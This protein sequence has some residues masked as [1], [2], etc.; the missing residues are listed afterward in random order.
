MRTRPA[1]LL[2]IAGV[3]F[4]LIALADMPYGY[5]TFLRLAVPGIAVAIAVIA[6]K[7]G[8]PGWLW[9]L[10]PIAIIWNPLLPIS[11]D[12]AAWVSLDVLAAVTFGICAAQVKTDLPTPVPR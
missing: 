11:M 1:L 4:S 8:A 9:A 12:R 10:I 3:I 6:A 5:Y 7:N 2:G